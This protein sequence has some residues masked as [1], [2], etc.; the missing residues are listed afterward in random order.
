MTSVLH[1][2]PLLPHIVIHALNAHHDAPCINTPHRVLTYAEVRAR[3]SQMVQA[4]H[5][6]GVQRGSRLA[7]LSKNRPEVLLNAFAS[8]VNGCILTPLHPMGSLGDH[9]YA[10]NDAE[11]DCLVFDTE[12]F[13]ERA[14]ELKAQFPH[15]TLL[16]F[17]PNRAGHD[18]LALADTFAP[19][20]L[21][22]PDV[23]LDDLCTV[24]YTGGTTGRPKGVLMSHR[25]WQS[26]TWIQ[27]S[28]WEF[29]DVIRI[30]L[31]TPL[32]HAA[33][34]VVSPVLLSGG[35]FYV[36]ESF[37]PDAFFDLVEQ[38][39]I[40]CCMLVPVMLYAMQ[41]HPRYRTADM[42]SMETIIYGASPISPAKLAEAIEHWG[43]I[44]FQFFGQTE[45]PM[46][47]THL[48]KADHDLSKAERLA[49]CGRPVPWM[50]VTLLDS[51][52]QPVGPGES[53]EICV[54]GPL[55]MNGYKDLP[56]ET[57]EALAGGWLHTGDVGRF[58]H[59]GFLYIVDRTKDMV[60][61]GGFNVFP[62]EVEDV[63]SEHPAVNTVMVIGVPDAKW[64]E[65]VKAVVVLQPG[66]A[67][68]DELTDELTSMVKRAKGSQQA[69]KS[70]DYTD[71]LPL[72]PVG[73]LDKKSM[74]A[75]YWDDTARSVS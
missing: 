31:P 58:D 4:M 34:S 63:I 17:G 42:S 6:V 43:P 5:S 71:S 66:H 22:A 29:P 37:S 67:P 50:H 38:H 35:T 59:E 48:K 13:T 7:I 47:I 16:G 19:A 40:T 75:R 57:A 61:T 14:A 26:M 52:N 36:M 33:L 39:R 73:K 53:G 11:I 27:M 60:I 8:L 9:A 44:F 69:P 32:S 62:R 49:S 18:F 64:G 72:T 65:A 28:E 68:S 45:A 56:D 2:Q 51:D 21:V 55:V 12:H 3:T 54:R 23:H 41:G 1:E 74:R 25:V 24:V 10:V 46:V 20:P 30:A 70:I 15:L